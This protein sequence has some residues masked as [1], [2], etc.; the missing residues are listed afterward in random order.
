MEL[1]AG[2]VPGQSPNREQRTREGASAVTRPLPNYAR[3]QPL[4]RPK[5]RE[6]RVKKLDFRLWIANLSDP[7]QRWLVE[8]YRDHQYDISFTMAQLDCLKVGTLLY[9]DERLQGLSNAEQ[10]DRL[11]FMLR[12]WT[13]EMQTY[14]NKIDE[15]HISQPWVEESSTAYRSTGTLARQLGNDPHDRLSRDGAST[16]DSNLDASGRLEGDRGAKGSQGKK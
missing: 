8:Q 15:L 3:T 10:R 12:T 11:L 5:G 7:W 13:T 16:R 4:R 6:G 1:G 14:G 9:H 2:L